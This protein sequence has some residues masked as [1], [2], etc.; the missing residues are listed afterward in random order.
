[1]LAIAAYAGSQAATNVFVGIL[2]LLIAIVFIVP[3]ACWGLLTFGFLTHFR[4]KR[5]EKKMGKSH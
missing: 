4:E 2:L 3:S 1:L 5:Q